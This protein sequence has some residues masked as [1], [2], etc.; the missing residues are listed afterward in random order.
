MTLGT[1]ILI[2]CII[3]ASMV[4][5]FGICIFYMFWKIFSRFCKVFDDRNDRHK[6][7]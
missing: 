2:F 7:V 5:V 3:V 4:L 1:G 6:I